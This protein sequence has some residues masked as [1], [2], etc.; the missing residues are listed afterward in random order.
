VIAVLLA[1]GC[2]RPD[3]ELEKTARSLAAWEEGRAKLEAGDPAGARERFRAA[4]ELR[5][6]PLLSAWE[7]RAAAAGG[8]LPAA[9]ALLDQALN[10]VP[11]FTEGRYNRAAYLARM[12]RPEAAA[13]DLVVALGPGTIRPLSVLEDSDFAPYLD[14]PSFAFLPRSAL[15]VAVEPPE[16]TAFWGAEISVRLRL[17]GI[18][19]PPVRF[20]PERAT[21]PLQLVGVVED[22]VSTAEGRALELVWTWKV[23]GAGKVEL[24]PIAVTAGAYGSTV[25]PIT[26]DA[27]APPDKAVPPLEPLTLPTPSELAAAVPERSVGRV[28]GAVVVRSSPTDRLVAE[29]PGLPVTKLELRELGQT[30][31][32]LYR[33][34][35]DRGPTKVRLTDATGTV[36]AEG[37]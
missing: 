11:G 32:I 17:L 37:P 13:E 31:E 9:V 2:H 26:V 34:P 8:D 6:S 5:P 25:D 20:V 12:G 4:S 7:A 23:V 1:L 3:P 24:G 30:R 33:W 29:P 18:V 10:E 22:T 35:A 15:S 36:V 27:Q 16:P 28:D 19:R 14:H 21:G